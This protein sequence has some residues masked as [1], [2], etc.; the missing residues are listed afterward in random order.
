MDATIWLALLTISGGI[1]AGYVTF[2]LNKSKE[3]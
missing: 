1:I 2:K 3:L